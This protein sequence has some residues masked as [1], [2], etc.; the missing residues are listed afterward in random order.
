MIFT[1]LAQLYQTKNLIKYLN[2]IPKEKWLASWLLA[3]KTFG[4][5][6]EIKY[7]EN[8]S[9]SVHLLRYRC[10]MNVSFLSLYMS[11]LRSQSRYKTKYNILYE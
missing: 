1:S 3:N 5:T 11:S 10:L 9:C 6:H 7:F 8:D 2:E 4:E